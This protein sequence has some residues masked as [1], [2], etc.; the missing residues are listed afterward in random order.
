[1]DTDSQSWD[2]V[3]FLCEVLYYTCLLQQTHKV[4]T[5]TSLFQFSPQMNQL[6]LKI[7]NIFRFWIEHIKNYVAKRSP[8]ISPTKLFMWS[9]I[10][11]FKK[12]SY[13]YCD[14]QFLDPTPPCPRI[15]VHHLHTPHNHNHPPHSSPPCWSPAC[16]CCPS[17]PCPPCVTAR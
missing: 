5:H 7:C 10:K 1:M 2:H 9:I 11:R 8:D 15:L 4:Y 6:H 12:I 17:S 14:Q 13:L 16:P 3:S